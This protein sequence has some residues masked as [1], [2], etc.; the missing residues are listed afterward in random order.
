M[1]RARSRI[2][3]RSLAAALALA[4]VLI[5]LRRVVLT[6]AMQ[7]LCA[8]LLMLLA[9]PLCRMLER[10]LP[11][12]AAAAVSLA[13]LFV[14]AVLALMLLVPPLSRQLQQ[15]SAA[16]PALVAQLQGLWERFSRFL[17]AYDLDPEP[18]RTGLFASMADRAGSA[19][20]TLLGGVTR[21]LSGVGRVLLAP[22]LAYYL[23]RDRKFFAM[24]LLLLTPPA[25]R[26]PSMRAMRII[27]KEMS[28]YFRGQLILS[29]TVGVMTALALLLTGTPAWLL[30]G[31]LMGVMELV[32]YVGPFI[33]GTPAVLLALQ[34]GIPRAL[35]TLGA[36]LLVQQAEAAFL[37]P[38]FLGSAAR[39]HPMAV[40]LLV[41]AGGVLGGTLGMLLVIPGTILLRGVVRAFRTAPA[42]KPAP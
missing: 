25:Y 9:L 6:L 27:R 40:L 36:I 37:S 30:L 18:L 4:G 29:G 12:G 26:A 13:M 16:L 20:S 24:E 14:G 42:R 10:R 35:L 1:E 7:L 5:L 22:L 15:L 11:P 19:L 21:F 28:A 38:R 33:A 23:L 34:S 32:P 3:L 39:L 41:S 17:A 31:A 2:R 8:L